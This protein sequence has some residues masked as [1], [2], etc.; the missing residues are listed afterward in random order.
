MA[1]NRRRQLSVINKV[2][3]PD[4]TSTV[5]INYSYPLK[6]LEARYR[7]N[8]NIYHYKNVEPEVWEEYVAVIKSGGSSGKFIN[9]RIKTIY[10]FDMIE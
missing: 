5:F 9:T 2:E 1:K 4:S 6:I 10:D 3:T 7:D 8:S